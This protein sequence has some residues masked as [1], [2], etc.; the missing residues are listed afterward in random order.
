MELVVTIVMLLVGFSV[1]LKLTFLPAYGRLAVSIIL[2]VF[3]GLCW[4]IASGQSKTIISDWLQNPVQM[5]DMA[6]LLTLDVF[7]QI[8][9]CMIES[10]FTAGEKLKRSAST[11]RLITLWIP[12]I[13]IF[14]T[15]LAILVELIFALPGFDFQTVSWSLAAVVFII[16]MAGTSILK[17]L[18]PERD[19]SLELIFMLNMLIA[20]LG[21]VATVN[22]KTAVAGS[23][24]VEFAPLLGTIILLTGCGAIG[25][26]RFKQKLRKTM[27]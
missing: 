2:A 1:L 7:I 20:L 24:D 4:N 9:F 3:T 25:F 5:L 13:L 15:L 26:V 23:N 14:P 8:S 12:G 11:I 6:V 21:V 17:L 19:L 27:Q 16:G 10:R 18:L 22:G